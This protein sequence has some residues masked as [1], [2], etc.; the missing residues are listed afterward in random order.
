M[1]TSRIRSWLS[2]HSVSIVSLGI[3]TATFFLKKYLE[4]DIGWKLLPGEFLPEAL[5]IVFTVLLIDRLIATRDRQSTQLIRLA[6]YNEANRML[7]FF[8]ETWEDILKHSLNRPIRPDEDIF[9]DESIRSIEFNFNPDDNR[10]VFPP[11]TWRKHL[12]S[13]PE[14]ISIRVDK[15]I[16]RYGVHLDQDFLTSIINLENIE[17]IKKWAV[18]DKLPDL[19][20][21]RP[22]RSIFIHGTGASFKQEVLPAVNT[23]YQELKLLGEDLKNVGGKAP[24]LRRRW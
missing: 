11:Y 17:A 3:L 10:A 7:S 8:I 20:A 6:A 18:L 24:L 16:Q 12:S 13:F 19:Y 14:Q 1:N 22:P 15:L 4:G 5:G 23:L 9:S 2:R 21:G